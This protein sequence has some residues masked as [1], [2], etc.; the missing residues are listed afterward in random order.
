MVDKEDLPK[1]RDIRPAVIQTLQE[2]DPG[3]YP[4]QQ[5][6]ERVAKILRLSEEQKTVPHSPEGNRTEIQYRT[7]WA[8]TSLRLAGLLDNQ[9][10]GYWALTR[11]GRSIDPNQVN[12]LISRKE[13]EMREKADFSWTAFYGE[14]ANKL[15]PFESHSEDLVQLLKDARSTARREAGGNIQDIIPN[16]KNDPSDQIDPFSFLAQINSLDAGNRSDFPHRISALNVIAKQVGIEGPVP[17]SFPGVSAWRRG[18]LW[19]FGGGKK[20]QAENLPKLWRLFQIALQLA[21]TVS[22]TPDLIDSFCSCYDFVV[23]KPD[24]GGISFSTF[25]NVTSA[26]SWYRPYFYLPINEKTLSYL[27]AQETIGLSRAE[28]EKYASY[29]QGYLSLLHSITNAISIGALN[30]PDLPSLSFAADATSQ[31]D[32][33][34]DID[35]EGN[36]IILESSEASGRRDS[37]LNIVLFGAPGTGKTYQTKRRA[38]GIIDSDAPDDWDEISDRYKALEDEGRIGFVTFHQSFSYEDFIEGIRPV[39]TDGER[40]NPDDGHSLAY[41]VEDG[42][43]KS[44]CEKA[45]NHPSDAYVFIIDELNRGNVAA[46]FGE[47]ITLLEEDKRLGGEDERTVL[48]P[49]SKQRWGIPSNVHI[50]ATMNTADRSLTKLDAAFRR[51]FSFEEVGPDYDALHNHLG[52]EGI[53]DGVDVH[54]MLQAMNARI[55]ALL[56]RDH[57]LGHS[58]FWKVTSLDDI[59]QAFASKIIP[60]L[61]DYFFEDYDLIRAVLNDRDGKFVRKI[62]D[63][64]GES[65]GIDLGILDNMADTVGARFEVIDGTDG[66]AWSAS[67]FRRIYEGFGPYRS[68]QPKAAADENNQTSDEDADA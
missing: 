35:G 55:E 59:R 41:A 19:F 38:I 12:D 37:P 2:L 66:D 1:Q 39:L 32:T 11:E 51:R 26:L 29:G 56:D 10:T 43:F 68:R 63:D 48:L 5:I 57:V 3:A 65:L 25:K 16:G 45:A 15:I 34:D 54:W 61:Q 22:P 52:N 31:P 47:L 50:I 8:R 58:L 14:L 36:P 60:L 13:K 42:V 46:I 24:K 7:A 17:T 23:P 40:T 28:I 4:I 9:R 33:G 20:H 67:D 53:V 21:D 18:G 6:N 62:G 27:P 30:Y 44:F 64:E 49:Y